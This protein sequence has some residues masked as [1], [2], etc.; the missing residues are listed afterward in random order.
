[1]R[2]TTTKVAPNTKKSTKHWHYSAAKSYK[3][4]ANTEDKENQHLK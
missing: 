3:K 2:G 1:M 4:C